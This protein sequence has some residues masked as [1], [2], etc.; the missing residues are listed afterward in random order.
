MADKPVFG[1]FLDLAHRQLAAPASRPVPGGE[2][3]Q[4]ACGSLARLT[5]V[6]QRYVRD[7]GLGLGPPSRSDPASGGWWRAWYEANAALRHAVGALRLPRLAV[8]HLGRPPIDSLAGR[9]DAATMTMTAGRDLLQTHFALDA[10]GRRIARTEWTAVIS[11]RPASAGLLAEIASIARDVAPQGARLAV[12]P[13]WRGAPEARRRM[14]NACQWLWILDAAVRQAQTEYPVGTSVT[15]LVRG[16]P[17]AALD[18]RPTPPDRASVAWLCDAATTSA[19]RTRR[20]AWRFNGHATWSPAMSKRSLRQVAATS[21]VTCRNCLNLLH[22]LA[23]SAVSAKDERWQEHLEAAQRAAGR[24]GQAWLDVA[25][26]LDSI[27]TD[28]RAHL[29]ATAEEAGDLALWTGRLAYASP[30]WTPPAGPAHALR[31]ASRLVANPADQPRVVTSVHQAIHTLGDLAHAEHEH[32]RLAARAGRILVPTRSIPDSF[33]IRAAFTAAPAD[34][35][36]TLL[37]VYGNAAERSR[38]AAAAVGLIAE[39]LR[40]PSRALSIA[41]TVLRD[42]LVLEPDWRVPVNETDVAQSAIHGLPGPLERILRDLNVDDPVML[43]RAA[44]L[45]RSG[46]RLLLDA[47]ESGQPV[48]RAAALRDLATYPGTAAAVD[49]CL[50]RGNPKVAAALRP[51][52][53]EPEREPG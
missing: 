51:R 25:H 31:P 4:E 27:T 47:A 5:V 40:T 1:D 30:H 13:G 44:D 42:D 20:A 29:S 7:I 32:I 41:R 34:R 3:I 9:L 28:T 39:R 15:E 48:P 19:E 6:L 18:P 10:D 2:D 21:T 36:H 14:T 52:A 50:A 16:L 11:S 46:D 26:A 35:I 8:Q 24:A 33:D 37:E 38:E 45:D 23:S 17:S 43:S 53:L 49:H 12:T 22:T